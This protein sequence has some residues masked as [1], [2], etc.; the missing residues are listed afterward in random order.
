MSATVIVSPK[1]QVTLPARVRRALGIHEGDA[2]R[3]EVQGD[4][5]TLERVEDLHALSVIASGYA[6]G[7]EPVMDVDAY[8]Q[9]HRGR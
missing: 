8:Y 1:G 3:I 4:A 6:R 2:L 9:E 5:I 7:A